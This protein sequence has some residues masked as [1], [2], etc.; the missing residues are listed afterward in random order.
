MIPTEQAEQLARKCAEGIMRT[1]LSWHSITRADQVET[2]CRKTDSILESI[3]LVE[4]IEVARA[5]NEYEESG[6]HQ[7]AMKLSEALAALRKKI[8]L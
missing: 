6:E 3:P 7:D 8:E 2:L 4:L 1:H 5:A